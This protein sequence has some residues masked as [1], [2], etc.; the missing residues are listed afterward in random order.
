MKR[1]NKKKNKILKFFGINAAGIKS[2]L[3]SFNQILINLK[4]HIWMIEETKL[5]PHEQIKCGSINDFQVYYLSRQES[6]GGGIALGVHKSLESTFINGG[7][8]NTEAISLLVVVGN[9]PIRIIVGYGVQENASKEKKDSFWDFIE[10]E[11][12][13][14]ENEE[15]GVV[16]QMDGNLHAGKNFI[17]NDPNS[18]NAN[19]KLFMQFLQ[20]NPTLTV[21]N[22][23]S[24]CEGTITRKREVQNK[25]ESAVLDFFIVNDKLSPFLKRMIIDEKRQFCLSNFAQ[26]KKNKKV[27]ESDHNGLI[28]EVEIEFSIG[29][30][31]R[32][33]IFNLKN[34]QCQEMFKNETE[35]NK[36]LLECFNNNLPFEVQAKR[37]LKNFNN[38]LQRCF[39]KIRICEN[40]NKTNKGPEN[41]LQERT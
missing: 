4:P 17:R 18:Q 23:L 5:K 16:I 24:I 11:V 29:A 32:P 21:V 38:I 20:R 28:L 35:V 10:K 33:E 36:D 6:Q 25:T 9:M 26:M 2:K 8:D 19:G 15:Q 39:K 34:K 41:W 22:S 13:A 30:S 14:A 1:N 12:T 7:N 40:K 37:W 31:E 27:I 3:H